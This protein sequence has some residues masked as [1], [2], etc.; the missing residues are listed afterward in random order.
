MPTPY[1]GGF[2]EIG[3]GKSGPNSVYVD[4]DTSYTDRLYQLYA[5]RTL[6]GCTVNTAQTRV[7]GQLQPDTPCS[8]RRPA[9]RRTWIIC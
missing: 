8:L 3:S 4:I 6:I 7:T 9:P 1:F 5:G 2:Q